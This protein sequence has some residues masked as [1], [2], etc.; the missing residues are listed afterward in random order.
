[1]RDS[2]GDRLILLPAAVVLP[3][4]NEERLLLV[5]HVDTGLW[6]LV[7]GAVELGESPAMAARRECREE[8]GLEIELGPILAAVG[9]ERFEVTYANGDRVAYVATVFE[10]RVIG[11]S[12]RPDGVEV[13]AAAWYTAAELR[14]RGLNPF[15]VNLLSDLGILPGGT[16]GRAG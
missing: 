6:G 10:A 4:D 16:D 13:D 14:T 8:T 15:C 2:V 12:L 1:L 3:R 7:G 5:R 11:G 9:G